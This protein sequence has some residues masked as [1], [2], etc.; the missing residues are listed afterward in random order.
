VLFGTHNGEKERKGGKSHL[1]A[2]GRVKKR[3][4]KKRK[5]REQYPFNARVAF[6]KRHSP[7]GKEE[8]KKKK[9]KREVD[10]SFSVYCFRANTDETG[11]KN[12]KKKKNNGGGLHS[13]TLR[14]FKT[15]TRLE[16]REEGK[17]GGEKKKREKREGPLCRT[18]FFHLAMC[19]P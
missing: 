3:E 4:E 10:F 9:K 7:V 13:L 5:K 6:H 15:A 17:K 19:A 8:K 12:K 14:G 1:I 11:E 16:R 2:S 18:S